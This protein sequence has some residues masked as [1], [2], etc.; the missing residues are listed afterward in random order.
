[1][2]WSMQTLGCRC[3]PYLQG[4][5]SIGV[6]FPHF[7]SMQALDLFPPKFVIKPFLGHSFNYEW[8]IEPQRTPWNDFCVLGQGFDFQLRSVLRVRFFFDFAS[9][10]MFQSFLL[11]S[12]LRIPVYL[13]PCDVCWC[14]V[15]GKLLSQPVPFLAS[16][17]TP[18]LFLICSSILFKS[19][20]IIYDVSFLARVSA[21]YF[22]ELLRGFLSYSI[23]IYDLE[24][25]IIAAWLSDEIVILRF[26]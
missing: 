1:M 22:S 24:M 16:Y 14:D 17:G 6:G 23:P 13:H 15:F 8:R 25:V 21:S 10:S 9:P 2:I 4:T 26:R 7:F 3:F 12:T 19:R 20:D 18:V 5:P 11:S